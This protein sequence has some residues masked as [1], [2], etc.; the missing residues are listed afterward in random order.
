LINP[1][2]DDVAICHIIGERLG[3]SLDCTDQAV[4]PLV[5][6]K[7]SEHYCLNQNLLMNQDYTAKIDD[8]V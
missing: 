1:D 8:L 2:V 7:T 4:T 6:Q 3:R 5:C